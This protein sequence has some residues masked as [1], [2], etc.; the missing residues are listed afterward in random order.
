MTKYLLALSLLLTTSLTFAQNEYQITGQV[1]DEISKENLNYCSV[2][3]LNQKDSII[4]GG[5]TNDN[6]YFYIPVPSG[7]YKLALNYIGYKND[8]VNIGSIRSDKF[9]GVLTLSLDSKMM[10]GVTVKS[11]SRESTIDKDVQIVTS[12]MRIGATDTKDLLS[13]VNGVSYDRYNNSVKVDNSSNIVILA[14][15]VEKDVDYIQ[16]LAPE[17]IKRIEIIRDPGGR[18]GLEG[19][20]A[21]VNVILNKNYV[22]SELFLFDQAL[23]DVTPK[24]KDYFFPIN[25]FKA[26]YNYTYNRV[27][28]YGSVNS[29]INNFGLTSNSTTVYDNDS[30]VS[31]N[32]PNSDAN[33]FIKERRLSYTVGADFYIN[34]KHTVSFESRI[35][36]F[37]KSSE[38]IN[39]ALNTVVEQKGNVLESYSFDSNNDNE[40]SR[41]NNSIFYIGKLSNKDRIETSFTFSTY[42][43]NY[44]NDYIQG[45]TN[46]RLETGINNSKRT[47]LSIE[48]NRDVSDKFTTQIGYGNY[49]KR[50]SNDFTVKNNDGSTSDDFY[51]QTNTRHKFYGNASYV[52]NEK[53]SA[54][55]GLAGETSHILDEN[56]DNNYFI[57]QPLFDLKYKLNKNLSFKFKYRT[58]SYYPSMSETNPFVNLIDPRT[59]SV[60]NPNLQPSVTHK[61]S[62]RARAIQG[63]ISI[64]P[65]YHRSNNYIGQIGELRPDGIFEFTYDN[66]GSYEKK[67]ILTNLTI[68]FSKKLIWQSSFNIYNSSI[69]NGGQTNNVN[70]WTADSQLIYMG[71]KSEGIIVL[72]YQ[73]SMSKQI[74][75]LGYDRNENDYWLLLVQ[76]P[77]FKKKLSVML[78]YFL[79]IDFGANFIQDTYTRT[80]GYEQ[81]KY[82]DI[83]LLKNMIFLKITYRINHGKIKKTKKNLNIEEE[84][85][86]GGIL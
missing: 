42:N 59:I 24:D 84:S 29:N 74:T 49:W 54:K 7:S 51:S 11:S 3:V 68:P 60:G 67:G 66:L 52:F 69:T 85:S 1:K 78:G 83:S 61:I 19:Y 62:L 10:D 47:N 21:I 79:P 32:P 82:V 38:K 48:Y 77:F 9:L 12:E 2:V 58:S 22:G 36:N 80:N 41:S 44:I 37:P 31:Q 33:L 20:S 81:N 17:R 65:Y 46:S 27:N 18:Y 5:V 76:Q 6:G 35:Q 86:G 73:R 8:T 55:V 26:S 72:N 15:G 14:D 71:M 40:S 70:D 30:I 43:N 64:E 53:I 45:T 39:Q 4:T 13:K 28:I 63:L 34:P 50:T 25:R 23:F 75:S 57:F 16:N 56:Q